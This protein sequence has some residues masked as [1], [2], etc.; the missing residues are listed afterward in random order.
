MRSEFVILH[1]ETRA[2]AIRRRG[3]FLIVAMVCLALVS[4]LL[5]S[6]LKLEAARRRQ[7]R[8]EQHAAQADWLVTSAIARSAHRFR[9]DGEYKG[10][11][12][13]ADVGGTRENRGRVEIVIETDDATDGELKD[14]AVRVVVEFP[15]GSERAVHRA[16]TARLSRGLGSLSTGPKSYTRR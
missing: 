2:S 12:W 5:T 3:G 14:P 16:R 9:L 1:N 4:V 8:H 10:E 6:L 7:A 15:E 11:T 13:T